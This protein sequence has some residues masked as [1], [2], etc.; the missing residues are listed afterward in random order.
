[1][2]ACN[3]TRSTYAPLSGA[4]SGAAAHNRFLSLDGDGLGMGAQRG[5]ADASA[6]DGEIGQVHDLARLPSH[7][8]RESRGVTG[9][10]GWVGGAAAVGER[11]CLRE[12][13]VGAG[14]GAPAQMSWVVLREAS[15]EPKV[16]VALWGV[17]RL[18]RS[19]GRMGA[20]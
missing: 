20:A 14:V 2:Y 7:L 1:M 19:S 8:R 9:D 13:V 11:G 12:V 10:A 6:R 17:A 3:T 16:G 15:S 5:D 18:C 4:V